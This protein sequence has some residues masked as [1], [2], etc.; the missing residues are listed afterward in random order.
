MEQSHL[1]AQAG[2]VSGI[3]NEAIKMSSTSSAEL[4]PE[5]VLLAAE[6]R[7]KALFDTLKRD[8][9]QASAPGLVVC[10]C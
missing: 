2:S 5:Q 6:D 10:K 8:L 9:Q 1:G 3:V 4:S 7:V